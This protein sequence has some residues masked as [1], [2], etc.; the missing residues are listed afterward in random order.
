MDQHLIAYQRDDKP[1]IPF[2]NQWDLPGGGREN[3][4]TPA[5]CALREV[6]EEF[7]LQLSEDRIVWSRCY[8]AQNQKSRDSYFLALPLSTEEIDLVS[9][10]DEGQRW[11]MMS[12]DE[13]LKHP[14]AVSFMQNRLRDFLDHVSS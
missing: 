9:F 6:E 13:Y 14:N 4:E 2:P 5:R 8:P 1:G 3:G 12:F 10:G 11:K 7:G